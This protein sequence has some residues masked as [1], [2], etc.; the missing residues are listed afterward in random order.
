MTS[1]PVALLQ[2]NQLLTSCSVPLLRH[3]QLLTSCPVPLLQHDQLLGH[4]RRLAEIE[5]QLTD[6]EATET[7]KASQ[8]QR[9]YQRHQTA[10]LQSEVWSEA[11]DQIHISGPLQIQLLYSSGTTS[12]I[13]QPSF[14]QRYGQKPQIRSTSQVPYRYSSFTAAT[15]PAA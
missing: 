2:H 13:R 14:S 9:H 1:C 6:L 8:Q 10:F 4:E 15:L 5:E 12:G 11:T 3:N 7:S